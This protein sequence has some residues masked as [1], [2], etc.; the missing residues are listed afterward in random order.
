MGMG[1]DEALMGWDGGGGMRWMRWG[2]LK[3]LE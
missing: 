2:E 1:M 3:S